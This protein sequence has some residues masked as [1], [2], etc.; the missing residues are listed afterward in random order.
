MSGELTYSMKEH[1][2][3]QEKISL[4][5]ASKVKTDILE[6]VENTRFEDMQ[7][8]RDYNKIL[9]RLLQLVLYVGTQD[10]NTIPAL[11]LAHDIVKSAGENYRAYVQMQ[12]PEDI[13]ALSKAGAEGL[14]EA[15]LSFVSD[16]LDK[17]E[18]RDLKKAL[19]AVG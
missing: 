15:F 3:L 4:L 8:I 12:L 9:S 19:D 14:K 2:K 6:F 11:K 1:S 5:P 13:E 17:K 10:K 18:Y 7:S 16:K